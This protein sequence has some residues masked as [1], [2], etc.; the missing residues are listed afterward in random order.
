MTGSL[1]ALFAR[2]LRFGLEQSFGTNSATFVGFRWDQHK[3]A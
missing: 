3:P 1:S 2:A